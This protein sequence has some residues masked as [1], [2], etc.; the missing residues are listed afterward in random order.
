[1]TSLP[2]GSLHCFQKLDS[3]F[4]LKRKGIAE[5]AYRRNPHCF[6]I[7]PH[8][9]PSFNHKEWLQDIHVDLLPINDLPLTRVL[10]VS[11]EG[12]VMHAQ[13]LEPTEEEDHIM[14]LQHRWQPEQH[15]THTGPS[16]LTEKEELQD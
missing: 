13:V 1:V 16:D 4:S 15:R 11:R 10:I 12:T 14:D 2:L 6:E 9:K 8:S 7:P 3:N 5:A